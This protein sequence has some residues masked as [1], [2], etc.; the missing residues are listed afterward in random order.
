MEITS[1]HQYFLQTTDLWT[2]PSQRHRFGATT[3]E[4][5]NPKPLHTM[6]LLRHERLRWRGERSSAGR[7]GL[8]SNEFLPN[9]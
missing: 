4:T 6:R 2:V 7:P 9:G 1:L 5:N 3:T 8:Q